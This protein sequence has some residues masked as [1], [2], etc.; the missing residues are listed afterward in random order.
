MPRCQQHGASRQRKR[1]AGYTLIELLEFIL[2]AFAANLLA[3]RLACYFVGAWH[4]VVFWLV[5]IVGTL[6]FGFLFMIGFGYLFDFIG[7]RKRSGVPPR[8]W[9]QPDP[10]RL[11]EVVSEQMAPD[12]RTKTTI[13][14]TPQGTYTV[15][16]YRYDDSD[17][18]KGFTNSVGWIGEMGPSITDRREIADRIAGEFLN[19]GRPESQ[20]R[21]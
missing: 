7:S 16:L 10:S 17:L 4:G 21:L 8:V 13:I 5:A 15:Y 9:H 3:D 14:R 19:A 11:G 20:A 18:K 6:A 2:A 12:D 1:D